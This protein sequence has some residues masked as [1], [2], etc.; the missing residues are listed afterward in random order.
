[1]AAEKFGS[2]FVGNGAMLG[3]VITQKIEPN[4]KPLSG[5]AIKNLLESFNRK[6]K[7]PGNAK[8]VEFIDA[9]L[10]YK[11]VG[12][13]PEDSQ[14]LETRKFQVEEVCRW[15]G[16]PPHKIASLDRS[17]HNNIESQNREVIQD[18]LL[19]WATRMEEEADIKLLDRSPGAGYYTKFN[20]GALLRGDMQA[21]AEYYNKMF[22]MGVF[23]ID[24]IREYEDHDPLPNG[25]GK[26]RLVPL[27]MTSVSKAIKDGGTGK[28]D[29]PTK[30]PSK[31]LVAVFESIAGRLLRKEQKA[32]ENASGRED[33]AA[34]LEAFYERHMQQWVDDFRPAAAMLAECVGFSGDLETRLTRAAG[35]Y[36][37]H[38]ESGYQFTAANL[39][40]W[41]IKQFAT[42]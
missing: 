5:D 13:P 21:R 10:E 30:T 25:D 31:A 40:D 27:N 26:L 23:D 28:A 1:L 15:F 16:V 36:H 17:T 33:E 24:E 19:P 20:F 37:Q 4:V 8:R 42:E 32:R 12:V 18:A 39:A 38:I 14:F 22:G 11:T 34:R 6:H 3:A 9:G 2:A 29:M 35:H 7:G 41:V